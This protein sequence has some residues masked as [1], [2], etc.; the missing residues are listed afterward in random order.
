VFIHRK[1]K[2]NL[3]LHK[4]D[5]KKKLKTYLEETLNSFVVKTISPRTSDD[6]MLT[7]ESAESISE[8]FDKSKKLVQHSL[9]ALFKHWNI[10]LENLDDVHVNI[11]NQIES[12][13]RIND[14]SD[15][16]K[17]IESFF[18]S[19]L[20]TS[21]NQATI[22]MN[23]L[24]KGKTNSNSAEL[25][26]LHDIVKVFL[27]AYLQY[28]TLYGLATSVTSYF[29]KSMV[30]RMV[31]SEGNS[32]DLKKSIKEKYKGWDEELLTKI[33][34][35]YVTKLENII[36]SIRFK[37][38]ST[39]DNYQAVKFIQEVI[40][41]VT[42]EMDVNGTMLKISLDNIN[43]D[44]LEKYAKRQTELLVI[45]LET[46]S[47][48]PIA[49]P[50]QC[51]LIIEYLHNP[52]LNEIKNLPEEEMRKTSEHLISDEISYWIIDSVLCL[53]K[54]IYEY[55]QM[56][57]NLPSIAF[58]C[59][60][61]LLD[62]LKTYNSTSLSLIL[63]AGAIKLKKLKNITAKHLAL[64]AQALD[65]LLGEFPH[66]KG[67]ASLYLNDKA[68]EVV[69]GD[70]NTIR[71]EYLKH[72]DDIYK[73]LS[74]LLSSHAM[75]LLEGMKGIEFN[76]DKGNV[77]KFATS[78][79]SIFNQMHNALKKYLPI[80]HTGLIFQEAFNEIAV[81]LEEVYPQVNISNTE[82]QAQFTRDLRE[83]E[84]AITS[85]GMKENSKGI[86]TRI[87]SILEQLEHKYN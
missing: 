65:A 42:R 23:Q 71:K 44:F 11:E 7:I 80:E 8:L 56:M 68:R 14:P 77:S 82:G 61:Q 86:L 48:H 75:D 9:E 78:I 35:F 47:W 73:K 19:T 66:I 76:E 43:K 85:L 13:L 84:K 4:N 54:I 46:E 59:V 67:R 49:V 74:S 16:I 60:N 58:N 27:V 37:T 83:I 51:E 69:E 50:K 15:V 5:I 72:R 63:G 12:L 10:Y 70:F 55:I 52:A 24:L 26:N 33:N 79:V 32:K 87:T 39:S 21:Y 40:S 20:N 38:E 18:N 45:Q 34:T 3:V 22:Y 57:Q 53:F 2:S 64:S 28:K 6:Y 62:T 41:L 29:A 1:L 31:N 30:Q 25:F 17:I 36:K 81:K